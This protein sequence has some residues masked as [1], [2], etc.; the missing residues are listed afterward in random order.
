MYINKWLKYLRL[1]YNTKQVKVFYNIWQNF[2][3]KFFSYQK[4]YDKKM[5]QLNKDIKSF[6]K[7]ESK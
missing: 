1:D 2:F 5:E 4:L 7:R 6:I 3:D